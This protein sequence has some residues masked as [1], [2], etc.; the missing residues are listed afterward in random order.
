MKKGIETDRSTSL[1]LI[2]TANNP[3]QTKQQFSHKLSKLFKAEIP[4]K[5]S[6]KKTT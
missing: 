3:S 1:L 4:G 5:I 2:N 6:W